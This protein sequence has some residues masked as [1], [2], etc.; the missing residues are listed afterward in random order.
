MVARRLAARPTSLEAEAMAVRSPF[1]SICHGSSASYV[2]LLP[3]PDAASPT[4][5]HSA[6][7][8]PPVPLS[9][10]S[11][12]STVLTPPTRT[13][14]MVP[15][16]HAIAPLLPPRLTRPPLF[17]LAMLLFVVVSRL[18]ALPFV[19]PCQS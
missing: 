4:T 17:A 12:G 10:Q 16:H 19:C 15:H 11:V 18:H 1:R 3:H 5:I 6:L 9:T 2:R 7:P 13:P 8:V 14:L